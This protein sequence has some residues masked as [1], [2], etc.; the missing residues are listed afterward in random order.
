MRSPLAP[1]VLAAWAVVHTASAQVTTESLL[2]ELTDRANLARLP[3]P[4]YTCRQFSSYDRASVSESD[5]NTWF[6]NADVGQFLR[7]EDS[8]ARKEWV[9]ADMPGPGA[10]VRIWS[11][12]PKG[13]LRIYLDEAPDP[14]IQAPMNDLLG[15]KWKI[16]PP[17]SH[18][19]SRGWNLYL[20]I[21][22]AKHCKITS[23]A[24]GFYY[25][26]N[27]RTYQP[28]TELRSLTPADLDRL[29]PAIARTN[30][31]LASPLTIPPPPPTAKPP[32]TLEPGKECRA[33]IESGGGGGDGSG[34]ITSLTVRIAADDL[35]A[36][37]RSTVLIG[38]FDGEQT[39]WCPLGDFFGSGVGAS[40]FSD[41]YRA[42]AP[43]G[44]FTCRWVMPYR[45]SADL[46]LVNLGA[47]PV[48]A[49][50]D[51]VH[52]PFTWDDRSMHFHA[53]WR[54]EYPIHAEGGRGTRDWN[55]LT[56]TDG[57]GV[58]VGDTLAVMNPVSDWWGEGD[59]KIYIDGEKFPSHFGTGTEDYYGYAWCCPQP[60]VN[61]FHSQPRCDG[62]NGGKRPSNW[63]HTTVTRVRAL[64]AIPFTTSFRFD[65]EVWHWKACDE[66]YAA[67]TYFYARPGAAINRTPDEAAARAPIPTPPARPQPKTF[68]GAI[69]CEDLHIVTKSPGV[70]AES[71]D[72]EHFARDAWSDGAHLW[73][74]AQKVGDFIE[75][76][77]PVP[78]SPARPAAKPVDVTLHATKSWDYGIVQFSLNGKP[79]GQPIDLF[80]NLH[81]KALPS[82]PIKLG[83]ATPR[84]GVIRLRAEL[85]GGNPK[86]EGAKSFF[87][88]DCLIMNE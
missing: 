30:A 50:I 65:M 34:A 86:A 69:E 36:A 27:Y 70:Q 2:S 20:P 54:S 1:I 68:A 17:L 8:G 31:S 33:A 10:I 58:Y 53:R 47:A 21:P 13:T 52:E 11:A 78:T 66:A 67:T 12:N 35:E 55:Y 39:I 25:Q 5:A 76:E 75:F 26:V 32:I 57:Q 72:M 19:A 14:V 48:S 45:Q 56:V 59:E 4:A 64:D 15:G 51:A 73:V 3:R 77:V 22:Y 41:L 49:S 16:A 84:D 9:M 23:D 28:G 88:L 40:A 6:A 62:W 82:G 63:G 79:A 60:F 42:V 43:D 24:D 83:P 81:G 71:Q 44:S 85:V 80:S 18:E 46:K 7:V 74:R 38:T 61:P 37:L 87:G 29:A